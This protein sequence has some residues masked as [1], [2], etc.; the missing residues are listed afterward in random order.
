MSDLQTGKPYSKADLPPL[1]LPEEEPTGPE[2]MDDE[3]ETSGEAE[4]DSAESQGARDTNSPDNVEALVSTDDGGAANNGGT[5]ADPSGVDTDLTSKAEWWD[6]LQANYVRDPVGTIL[7]HVE[8]MTPSDKA[9]FI[10]KVTTANEPPPAPW[11]E[12][13]SE[14]EEWLRGHVPTIE[15]IPQMAQQIDKEFGVRDYAINDHDVR[16]AALEAQNEALAEFLEVVLPKLDAAALQKALADPKISNRDAV[17]KV[18]KPVVKQALVNKKQAG[19]KRPDTP[20]NAASSEPNVKGLKGMAEIM[21]Q[22]TGR[23]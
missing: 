22:I 9:A 11:S 19:K 18:Y 7:A 1:D 12:S 21:R 14:A 23:G 6:A 8:H 20:G 3:G 10:E 5:D 17:A 15:A 4:E 16:L 13:Q 2:D